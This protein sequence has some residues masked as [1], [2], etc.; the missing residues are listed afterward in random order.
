MEKTSYYN[1]G[2]LAIQLMCDEGPFAMLTVNLNTKLAA[3]E[4][5]VDINNCPWAEAFIEENNLGKDTGKVG[6]S[7]FCCYPLYKFY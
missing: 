4:A 6:F 2:N 3:D 5:Y 7:G 1:N